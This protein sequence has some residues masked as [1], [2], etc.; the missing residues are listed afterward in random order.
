M[1]VKEKSKKRELIKPI[2]I[3]FRAVLL[4]LTFFPNPIM[5]RSRAERFIMVLEKKVST[6]STARNTMAMVLISSLFFDFSFTSIDSNSSF[7]W[8]QPNL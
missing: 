5:T 3:V 1:E 7:H 2:A 4:V 6:S 8:G